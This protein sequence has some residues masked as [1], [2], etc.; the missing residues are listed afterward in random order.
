MN[1]AELEQNWFE[2]LYLNY[3]KELFWIAKAYS[4]NRVLAEDAVQEAFLYV[5][6]NRN[7]LKD[8]NCIRQYLNTTVR[9]YIIDF[10]R[11]QQVKEKHHPIIQQEILDTEISNTDSDFEEKFEIATGLIKSLPETCRK[12]FIMA[13]IEGMSYQQV[14]ENL[15]ISKNTVKMQMKIAYR[16]LHFHA[17]KIFLVFF[18]EILILYTLFI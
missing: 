3:S 15:N 12:I 14:A 5:W 4:N 8:K 16:K 9:N 2:E 18:T 1:N 13:V 7:E 10:F 17:P 6:K 11:H